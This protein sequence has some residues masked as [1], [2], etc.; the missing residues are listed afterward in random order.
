MVVMFRVLGVGAVAAETIAWKNS[1]K[2]KRRKRRA[3]GII[4][5]N[6]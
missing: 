4:R 3:K 2:W 1:G 5:R 6:T